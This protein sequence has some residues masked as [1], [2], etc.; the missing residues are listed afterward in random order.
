M[1]PEQARRKK[2][3]RYMRQTGRSGCVEGAEAQALLD[4]IAALNRRGMTYTAMA[5]QS[6][7]ALTTL[8]YVVRT[9]EPRMWRTT[10]SK[11]AGL[12]F[13]QSGP[14]GALR[15]ALASQRK[16]Q[17]LK[18][19]GFTQLFLCAEL[20]MSEE[21]VYNLSHQ[22]AGKVRLETELAVT[23]LYQKY[24]LVNPTDLGISD[25]GQAFAR[26]IARKHGWAPPTCWDTDTISDPES[27][28]EWTGACGTQAGCRLHT[29]YGIPRCPP[30]Q[31]A[32]RER[33]QEIKKEKA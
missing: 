1:T 9:G 13:E 12:Q 31:A 22:V 29:K 33:R 4:T 15:P 5:R 17:A 10:Y 3:Q 2:H 6:G 26:T 30:C 14:R 24:E 7:V 27:I 11:L 23:T 8:H 18:A 32:D 21:G 25:S 19:A 20:S 16:I 28:P